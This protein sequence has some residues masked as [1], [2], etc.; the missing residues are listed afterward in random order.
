M[1]FG[2]AS[3]AS[4]PPSIATP[5]AQSAQLAASAASAASSTSRPTSSLLSNPGRRGPFATERF[6]VFRGWERVEVDLPLRVEDL[7]E[8][9]VPI[10]AGTIAP[11]RHPVVLL[12]HGR[13]QWCS[14]VGGPEPDP[15]PAWCNFEGATIPVPSYTGYR[16][17]A[18][19]LASQGRIV[20]SI[21]ANGINAQDSNRDLGA[22]ARA[23][24]IEYHL[25]RLSRANAGRVAGYGDRL[26]GH[27][28]LSRTVLMGHSR[29]GEGVVRSAQVTADTP[30]LPYRLVGVIPLAPTSY[31]RAAPPTVPTVTILPSCDG[32]VEDLQGQTYVDRGR[33]LYGA[34]G[35]LSSS[36]WVPGGNHNYFNTEWTPGL[37]VSNTGWDDADYVYADPPATGSCRSD[38]RLD[39]A[40]VRHVG[41]QYMAAAVRLMQDGDTSL[42]PLFDGGGAQVTSLARAGITVRSASLAGPDR[43]LLAPS[44]STRVTTSG[45]AANLCDGSGINAALAE[46]VVCASDVA[47]A[48]QDTMWLGSPFV[49]GNLA[50]RTAINVTWSGPGTAFADLRQPVNLRTATRLSARVVLDPE[51][52]GTVRLAVRDAKGRIA[53]ANSAG[54]PAIALTQGD[55]ELRLW[56]QT[57][58]AP[59]SAFRGV[60]LSRIVAVGLSTRGQGRAWLIDA[61]RRLPRGASPSTALP[62]AE[63]HDHIATIAGGTTSLIPITIVL[64]RPVRKAAHL[65]V[66]VNPAIDES[67]ISGV[68]RNVRVAPGTRRA[69]VRVPVTMPAAV[70]PGATVTVGVAIY[71]LSGATVGMF[72][73]NLTVVPTNVA[74]RTVTLP[75]PSV[76]APAG[77]AL[78]WEFV[79]DQPGRV[80]VA[81]D[82]L[83]AGM[84]FADIDPDFLAAQGLP[85]SGPITSETLLT[86]RST[87]VADDRYVITLPLSST[88][89]TG[90]NITFTV[91]SVQGAYAPDVSTLS[92]QVG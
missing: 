67:I 74:L 15:V 6:E 25:D 49:P 78:T 42:Q 61:S 51:A 55:A 11:G 20:I 17:L 65:R 18:N 46:H 47:T 75:Q 23:L 86:L 77:G 33:D 32:D 4:A 41:L 35:A 64:N 92:G 29:G 54:L 70:G 22:T 45:L 12:L 71:A 9:T 84:D 39:S 16:Y 34:K 73:S 76:I 28:D 30:G 62:V 57:L 85:T 79:A 5:A 19:A 48:G 26:V 37:S 72:R 82:L 38:V 8:I 13:H 90:A 7:A 60:D 63:V 83:S 1:A 50:G 2:S 21:S 68:V 44:P 87:Q 80:S 53:V 43:L 27:V 10:S 24:L 3:A 89:R 66:A 56:A 81:A 91:T 40:A 69:T 31:G 59:T 88:A 36:V 14:D 52:Q 58:W